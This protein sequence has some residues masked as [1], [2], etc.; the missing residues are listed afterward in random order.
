MHEV[1]TFGW[2]LSV[3]WALWGEHFLE[4]EHFRVSTFL[5]GED[6]LKGEHFE[7]STF[8]EVST[9]RRPLLWG[10]LL[11]FKRV[12]H[13]MKR[14]ALYE[15]VSTNGW[16]LCQGVSTL[17]WALFGRWALR[18]EHYFT[19]WAVWGEHC[20]W[21]VNDIFGLGW[22]LDATVLLSMIFPIQFTNGI[23]AL[24]FS[25]FTCF[26]SKFLKNL[27]CS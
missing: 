27:N 25:T 10:A 11:G 5:K 26:R 16:A 20:F 24:K 6:F 23:S 2:A 12:E 7:E 18:G 1:S 17:R 8:C 9:F 13:F 19:R 15:E 3:G 21:E 14:W 22:T 4:G